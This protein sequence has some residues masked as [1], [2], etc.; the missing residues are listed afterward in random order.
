MARLHAVRIGTGLH[1]AALLAERALA[2]ELV[3]A[4]NHVRRVAHAVRAS[5]DAHLAAHALLV[6]DPN[7]TVG[8]LLGSARRAARH[9]LGILAVHAERRQVVAVDVRPR[10]LG[11]A[12]E[13]G[14]VDDVQRQFVP[15]AACD[16][17]RM[18]ADAATLVNSHRVTRHR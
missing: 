8:I 1:L 11:N 13:H 2:H 15:G 9:A 4:T 14:V 10:A 3:E 6:V 16:R 7:D 17:A 5:V 18:A 12:A